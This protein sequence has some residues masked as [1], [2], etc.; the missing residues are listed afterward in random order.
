MKATLSELVLKSTSDHQQGINVYD[1]DDHKALQLDFG[2]QSIKCI[3]VCFC[4]HLK[5][6]NRTKKNTKC[7]SFL[8]RIT[9]D[10]IHVEND[11]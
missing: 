10:R 11:G 9:N 7:L 1:T 5:T 8:L 2:Q 6:N 4:V 3:S